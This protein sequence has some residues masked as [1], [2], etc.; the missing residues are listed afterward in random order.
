MPEIPTNEPSTIIAGDTIRWLKTLT[1]YPA[2]DGWVLGYTLVNAAARLVLGSTAQG[3]S[4]LVNV[5][6]TTT[7]SGTQNMLRVCPVASNL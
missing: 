6:A 1:D 2:S 5:S 3:D 7:A 4:H